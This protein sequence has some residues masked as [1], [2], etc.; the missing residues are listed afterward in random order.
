MYTINCRGK[1]INLEHPR[2]MG[3]L[4][5]TPDSFYKGFAGSSTQ[6]II[7]IAGTMIREGASI[8]DIGGQSSRPGSERISSGEE[9]ERVLPVIQELRKQ[10]PA[11]LI[12]ID[13]YSSHVAECAVE[14]GAEI[15]N[16]ISFGEMDPEMFRVAGKLKVPYIGMHMKGRPENMQLN[17]EYNDVSLEVLQYFSQRIAL[18]KKA[19]IKDIILDPGFGFGKTSSHNMELLYNLGKLSVA[20]YPLLAGLSRKSTIS[21]ILGVDSSN[22]LNGTTILNTIALLNGVS[23]IRVHDVKESVECIKL[24]EVYKKNGFR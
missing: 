16:D 15:I 23:I 2:V 22:A 24:V 14:A 19:G 3:I 17:P 4:N 9:L 5:I 12:S 7:D 8:I 13:T 1:L 21:K 20:G 10:F 6:E 18:A 11:I